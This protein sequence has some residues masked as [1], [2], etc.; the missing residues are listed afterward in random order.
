MSYDGNIGDE[1]GFKFACMKP[2]KAKLSIQEFSKPGYGVNVLKVEFPVNMCYVVETVFNTDSQNAY[3]REEVK[4]HFYEAASASRVPIIPL[5][6]CCMVCN[7]A[8][9]YSR[10]QSE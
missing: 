5:S 9:W 6:K 8:G 7:M 10:L 2:H 1:K 4:Q 3:Y